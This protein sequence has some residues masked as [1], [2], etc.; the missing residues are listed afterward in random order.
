[1]DMRRDQGPAIDTGI[2]ETVLNLDDPVRPRSIT[3]HFGITE[4][5]SMEAPR[6]INEME[7]SAGTIWD[8]IVM[9]ELRRDGLQ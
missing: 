5:S 7:I 2:V 6:V 9:D 4:Q 3:S 1:M 8:T